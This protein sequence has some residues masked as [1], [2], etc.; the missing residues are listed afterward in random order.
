MFSLYFPFYKLQLQINIVSLFLKKK[1]KS[2]M[3]ANIDLGHLSN[4]TNTLPHR[5]P[6]RKWKILQEVG[7]LVVTNSALRILV[8]GVRLKGKIRSKIN[9]KNINW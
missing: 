7:N 2:I 6:E 9:L 3:A 1:K 4:L 8:H 5:M